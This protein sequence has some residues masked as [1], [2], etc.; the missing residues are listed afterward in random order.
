MGAIGLR[1]F[2]PYETYNTRHGMYGNAE[3]GPSTRLPPPIPHSTWP[4]IPPTGGESET[5][6]DAEQNQSVTE[7]EETPVSDFYCSPVHHVTD[8]LS[9]VRYPEPDAPAA[10][11]Q[12]APTVRGIA[13][14]SAS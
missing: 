2:T 10:M 5:T 3:A 4:T 14:M 6:A 1:R 11:G 8:R 13:V 9:G 12:H 7:E